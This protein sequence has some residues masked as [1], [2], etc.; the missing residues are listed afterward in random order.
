MSEPEQKSPIEYP[1]QIHINEKTKEEYYVKLRTLI[2][3]DLFERTKKSEPAIEEGEFTTDFRDLL[4]VLDDEIV[5]DVWAA[6]KQACDIIDRQEAEHKA[7]DK[8]IKELRQDLIEFGRHSQGCTGR[9]EPYTCTCGWSKVEQALKG[10]SD[11][12]SNS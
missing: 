10:D 1:W 2:P 12:T 3:D 6:A 7:K 11:E 4:F 9:F 8:R 5:P